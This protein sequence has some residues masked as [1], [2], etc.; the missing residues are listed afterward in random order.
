[1]WGESSAMATSGCEV[2]LPLTL[3]AG[4]GS[5]VIEEAIEVAKLT[6]GSDEEVAGEKR[7]G[8]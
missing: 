6:E 8:L 3:C 5:V 1:L 2:L 4:V 7:E